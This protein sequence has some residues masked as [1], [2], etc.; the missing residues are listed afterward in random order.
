MLNV[1]QF[2][3]SSKDFDRSQMSGPEETQKRAKADAVAAKRKA[4]YDG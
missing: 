1:T 3:P 2:Q 4:K